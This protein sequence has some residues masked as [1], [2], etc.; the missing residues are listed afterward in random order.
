MTLPLQSCKAPNHG[1]PCTPSWP[2]VIN[3]FGA[4][5]FDVAVRAM[6]GELDPPVWQGAG[7]TGS[8]GVH[9]SPTSGFGE[10]D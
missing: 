2:Q 7:G 8:C 6:R 9:N 3:E 5:R 10:R 1:T 4:T